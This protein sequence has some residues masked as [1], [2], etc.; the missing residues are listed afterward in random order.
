MNAKSF[1]CIVCPAGC[2]LTATPEAA[3]TWRVEGNRCARGN[4][5]ALAEMTDP[6]RT[7]TAVVR[8][9]S[10]VLPYAPVRTDRPIARD[11]VFPL[12]K[13]LCTC[14]VRPPFAAGDIV[15]RD[16]A[17]SGVNVFLT[18]SENSQPT[19]A[20]WQTDVKEKT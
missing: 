7:V 10:A 3:G 15:L 11:L 12:L 5:Y 18:R 2:R 8:T 16:F 4:L 17:G 14:E 19:P 13:A 9:G 1:T 20:P 6:K